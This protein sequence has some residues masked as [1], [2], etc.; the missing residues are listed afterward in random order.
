VSDKNEGENMC[1][2]PKGVRLDMEPAAEPFEYTFFD[3][4]SPSGDEDTAQYEVG[5]REALAT[6]KKV[7]SDWAKSLSLSDL[8]PSRIALPESFRDA[9]I[10]NHDEIFEKACGVIVAAGYGVYASD[11]R[12][13][14]YRMSD[15]EESE[16]PEKEEGGCCGQCTGS[17][18]D[19]A[20]A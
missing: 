6:A 7:L 12:I 8:H 2:K 17:T 16:L 19:Q 10:G 15:I 14:I 20:S 18:T 3:C 5:T 4:W 11:D 13:E 1:D 9:Y